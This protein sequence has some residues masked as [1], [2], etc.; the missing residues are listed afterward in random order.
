MGSNSMPA[1][2]AVYL[3]LLGLFAPAMA[4]DITPQRAQQLHH[5]VRHDCGS[6]HGMT[7]RGGLG[8]PLNAQSLSHMDVESL[9][10]IILDGIPN[11]AMPPWRPLLSE[12]DAQWIAVALKTGAIK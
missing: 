2:V 11:T 12:A 8:S 10:M 7:M 5:L 6:C 4:G 1:V 9:R 3:A